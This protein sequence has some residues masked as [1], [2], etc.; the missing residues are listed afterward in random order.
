M[1]RDHVAAVSCGIYQRHAGARSRLCRGF[2]GRHRRQ[3]RHDRRRQHRRDPGHRREGA[4]HARSELLA[5]LALAPQGHRASWST[6]RSWRSRERRAL[7]QSM[8]RQLTGRLVIAT[9]NPGKLARCANCW[10]R[11][12]SRR[13][14][15]ANSACPSRTRPATPSRPMRALKADAAAQAQ[16][17]AG[18]RRRFRAGVDALDGEPGIYSARWAG[19]AKDFTARDDAGRD[20]CCRSRRDHARHSA[21]RISSPRCA[22]PGPTA[23]SRTSRRRV[24]GTLVWPPRGTAASATIRCSCPTAMTRTF[25]E[26]TAEREARPAAA[27]PG[28]VASRTRL[29]QARGDRALSNAT[30]RAGRFGVY[31]HWPFCLSKCPYCD[32][33]S[34]VRHAPIDEARFARA[35]ARE[36]ATTAQRTAGRTVTSIFFGGGTPSLMKPRNR[37]RD[38]RRHRQALDRR[39]RRRGHAGGQSDQRRGDALSRLSRRRRQPRLARRAGA[40]RCVAEGARPAAHRAGSAR[41]RGD[42]AQRLRALLVRPDLCAPEPDARRCGATN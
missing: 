36:I 2:R 6:C 20:A 8:H 1:L 10:R 16:R 15:P 33:N 17:P 18:V 19:E 39:A 35:F 41:R 22:S 31:V 37:R 30:A 12:A 7:G 21:R 14:R 25:G 28:P 23:M 42:R 32:F 27:R 40:R 9:H 34:H 29:R 13:C 38:P 5:L 11:T 26:M 24:D 3:F 4:V